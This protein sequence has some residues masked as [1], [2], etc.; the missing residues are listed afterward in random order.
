VRFARES[1][2][3]VFAA[4]AGEQ[5]GEDARTVERARTRTTFRKYGEMT[6]GVARSKVRAA[7]LMTD[8]TLLLIGLETKTGWPLKT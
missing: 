7:R 3:G 4:V 6:E 2:R 8:R 5:D 1:P